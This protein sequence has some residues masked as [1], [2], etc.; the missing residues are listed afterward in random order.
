MFSRL[1]AKWFSAEFSSSK[2]YK[3]LMAFV[4][5]RNKNE[6]IPEKSKQIL[7]M[8]F[9]QD[10]FTIALE[11]TPTTQSVDPS[12]L[13]LYFFVLWIYE[14]CGTVTSGCRSPSPILQ[15][16][17]CLS[18]RP[19]VSKKVIHKLTEVHP[20]WPSFE[21][22]NATSCWRICLL[23]VDKC[24]KRHTTFKHEGIA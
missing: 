19:T 10:G 8:T 18:I 21:G 2:N 11:S 4:W 3:P 12:I 9:P 22:L 14:E 23:S 17:P 20:G 13:L 1:P 5:K 7:A 24:S 6:Y 16:F 15:V